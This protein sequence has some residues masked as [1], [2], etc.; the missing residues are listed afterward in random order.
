[1]VS[2]TNLSPKPAAGTDYFFM[3]HYSLA[4]GGQTEE[5]Y[6][7]LIVEILWQLCFRQRALCRGVGSPL[8]RRGGG[9]GKRW[10][11]GSLLALFGVLGTRVR[12]ACAPKR[13][14]G[15]GWQRAL[16]TFMGGSL[17]G[18]RAAWKERK[19]WYL[20]HAPFLSFVVLLLFP[21]WARN[22][23]LVLRFSRSFQRVIYPVDFECWQNSLFY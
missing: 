13:F 18:W 14:F 15:G 2:A 3:S 5:C 21:I 7:T 16:P 12:W 6:A 22:N 23:Q 10:A 19:R 8:G 11:Q 9:R 1:M 4:G 20:S 17:E